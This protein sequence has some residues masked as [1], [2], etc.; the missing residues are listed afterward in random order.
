[1]SVLLET[2][3]PNLPFC[4]SGARRVFVVKLIKR[5]VGRRVQVSKEFYTSR[6]LVVQPRGP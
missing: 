5:P 6:E 4:G 2:A 3:S 1:M